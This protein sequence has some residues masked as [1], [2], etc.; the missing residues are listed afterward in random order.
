LTRQAKARKTIAHF[1]YQ[2]AANACCVFEFHEMANGT[3]QFKN[4]KQ[5]FAYQHFLLI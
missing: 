5:L 3:A 4:C 2:L 1:Y